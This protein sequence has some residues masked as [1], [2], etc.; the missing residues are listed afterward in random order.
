MGELEVRFLPEGGFNKNGAF[1]E[2]E[3][4]SPSGEETEYQR[5]GYLTLDIACSELKVGTSLRVV[6]EYDEVEN[7]E[8][9]RAIGANGTIQPARWGRYSLSF[10]GDKDSTDKIAITIQENAV[11]EAATLAGINMEGDLDV[12]DN[13]HFFLQ[14]EMYHERF[15]TLL[16]ELS[17]PGAVLHISVRADRFQGFYAEWSPSISEGRVIKFLNRKL[18]VENADEIPEDFWRTTEFQRELLSNPD[19]PPVT[20][21]IRRPLQ[22]IGFTPAS[23]DTEEDRDIT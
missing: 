4:S 1:I 8:F 5:Q 17:I 14:V 21:S 18:D 12:E 19:H 11:G 7:R 6:C 10:L 2:Y 22:S 3:G 20:I 23:P 15:A 9:S 13:H 16:E